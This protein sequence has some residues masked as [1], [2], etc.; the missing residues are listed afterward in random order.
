MFPDEWES[1]LRTSVVAAEPQQ[2]YGN[3]EWDPGWEHSVGVDNDDRQMENL[4]RWRD[5]KD[6]LRRAVTSNHLQNV[7]YLHV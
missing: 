1:F 6:A 4:G 2:G 5:P 7:F 3:T